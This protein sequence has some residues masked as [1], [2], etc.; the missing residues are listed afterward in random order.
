MTNGNG[1]RRT[2][3][4][5]TQ[6]E[7]FIEALAEHG[8]VRTACRIA[9]V[10]R[11]TVYAWR[12]EDA[13]FSAAWETALAEAVEVLEEEARRR[14]LRAEKPS[15]TLL[16][17]LLKSLRPQRYCDAARLQ[18]IREGARQETDQ[19]AESDAEKALVAA[20]WLESMAH[21]LGTNSCLE[22]VEALR[23]PERFVCPRA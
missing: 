6:G 13:T 2:P 17:F 21:R 10:G 16:I 14:A 12:Q 3:K 7:Q 18:Q 4:K 20:N 15:D 1:T 22:L 11:S 5:V 9:V 8:N 19:G 23:A